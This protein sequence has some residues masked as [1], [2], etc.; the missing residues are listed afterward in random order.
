VNLKTFLSN[1]RV[2]WKTFVFV[3]VVL[4]AAGVALLVFTPMQYVSTT[5]LMVSIQGSTTAAAY[6]NDG[7]VTGRVNSYI[8][9]LTSDVASQRVIDKLGLRM[10]AP[11]LAAKI[12]A[13][14]VPPN[15]SIID[16]T[17]TDPSPEQARRIADTLAGEFVSFTEALETPTGEDGQK[18]HTTVVTAAS[19]PKPRLAERVAL[20]VLAALA[21]LLVAAVVVWIRSVTDRVVRTAERAAVAAGV[22]VLGSV[23]AAAAVSI[24]DLEGYR[25]LRARL[26]STSDRRGDRVLEMASVDDDVDT[27][28]VAANLG[29]AMELAGG[30]A[31]VID[32]T[33]PQSPESSALEMV[34]GVDGLPDTLSV[35]GWAAVPDAA[36]TRAASE[37]VE[38]L[39]GDYE[40][41]VMAA[42]PVLTSLTASV[43]SEYADAILLLVSPGRTKRRDV[44]RAAASLVAT[45]APLIGVL[46]VGK[47]DVASAT[48]SRPAKR[49]SRKR[50]QERAKLSV[51]T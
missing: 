44:N 24:H 30:R 39:R 48:R 50:A 17:V 9:L 23:T 45:G 46:L 37:L 31:V 49:D 41:V 29:R 13:T 10:T 16:V 1:V 26:R 12:S 15:T 35:N 36:A 51:G 34:R 32:A 25:R 7:V 5:Q 19:E 8:A 18:V 22:P 38:R 33:A 2:Y 27:P 4:L 28:S 20:G 42:P 14:N 11:E 40:H 3:T 6:Q 21:A 43:V 47:G